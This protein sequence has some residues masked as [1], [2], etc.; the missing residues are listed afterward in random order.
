MINITHK[1]KGQSLVEII[2][3]MAIFAMITGSIMSVTLGGLNGLTQGGDETEAQGLAEE[4]MEAVRSVRDGAWNELVFSPTQVSINSNTWTLSSGLSDLIDNKYTRSIT[5]SDVCRDGSNN[6]V[7]CPGTYTDPHIKF[8][9]TT[10]SWSPRYNAT[11][12]IEQYG[13]ITNWESQDWVQTNWAGSSGQ[14]IWS[15]IT[16]YFS[17]DGGVDNTTDG[18][19]TLGPAAGGAWVLSG[20]SDMT[21]TTDSNFNIGT[22]LNTA[23]TGTGVS[24]SVVLAQTV[25]WSLFQDTGTQIWNGISCASSTDC[26]AVGN[27][28]AV[29]RYNGT[30]WAT[31]TAISTLAVNDLAIVSPNDIWAVGTSGN[32]WHYN[33]TTW[34]L[35]VDTGTQSWND[36]VC[37]SA[38]SCRAVGGAGALGYYNGV[39]WTVS[40]ISPSSNIN[41]VFALSASNIYAAGASGKIWRYNGTAWAQVIDTGNEGWNDITCTSASSC[42]TVGDAGAL[43]YYNGT[44]WV[45]SVIPS[46]ASIY[47][48]YA[49]SGSNIWAAGAS[50][51]IWNYNGTAWSFYT[52]TGTNTWR[53]MY[54]VSTDLGW[55]VDNGGQFYKYG[56]S[57]YPSGTFTS[58]IFDSG[59]PTTVW[60]YVNWTET[61]PTG[62]NITVSVRTGNTAIPDGTWSTWSAELTDNL[63]SAISGTAQYFQY[64]LTFTRPANPV[65]TVELADITVSYNSP[66]TAHLNAVDM[67]NTNFGFA[68]GAGGTI[69][70]YDGVA[71]LAVSSPVSSGLNDIEIISATDAWA[72]GDAG[73]IL[74]Y[75]G[76]S[77]SLHTDTGANFWNAISCL[78]TNYCWIAGNGGDL[79][80][81]N[82]FC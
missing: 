78:T 66:T 22:Y 47:T 1:Q 56:G 10:V 49:L 14:S 55:L 57:Y 16:K 65:T 75:N 50:G 19:I 5:L 3:A 76:T 59:V 45:E 80:F 23:V 48:V 32:I 64:R 53:A 35:F 8:A 62:G 79:R 29:A 34:S 37:T 39:S 42:W 68:V 7:N 28:G 81:W 44:T 11:N 24:A 58:R 73:I 52:S 25:S 30:T 41:T 60:S 51:R 69:L 27:T 61:I 20:G 74:Y 4:A 2:I 13:F 31:I 15:D 82:G 77:W 21:D 67:Y 63:G 9:S 72:V 26:W 70:K 36:V 12:T 46:S 6:I 17:D 40:T 43:A 18:Q 33:G 71:W 54:F 38:S